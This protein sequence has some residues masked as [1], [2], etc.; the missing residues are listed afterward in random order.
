VTI[1]GWIVVGFIAGGLAR[2]V[3]GARKRGC[4]GTIVVGVLGGLLGGLIFNA[5]AHRGITHFGLW[6]I[7]VA[8]VGAS[9]LLL[10]LQAISGGRHRSRW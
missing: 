1:L 4:I 5:A 8:F 7:F 3:T 2:M 9:L 10:L 6:S